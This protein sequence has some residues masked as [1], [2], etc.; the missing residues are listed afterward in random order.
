[1]LR[2]ILLVSLACCMVVGC[3]S[4]LQS[5][6]QKSGFLKDYRFFKPNPNAEDSWIRTT[7]HFDLEAFQNYDRI[8]I[9]PIE[10]WIDENQEY[11]IKD[12]SKQEALTRYL[13][14]VIIEKLDGSKQVVRPGT[15]GSLLIKMAI[16][17]YGEKAPGFEALD[18][19]PFRIVKNVG[20]E[21]YLLASGQKNVIG[22]AGLEA[23]FVDTD[24]GEGLA[25]IILNSV[26]D[27]MNVK[28]SDTNLDAIKA[29]I[30]DWAN[31]LVGAFD[32]TSTVK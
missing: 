14:Q 26:T 12:P 22:S 19:L 7:R 17:H 9:A 15:K 31:R 25:A 4:R 24:S 27:E 5:P 2:K 18:V 1:M 32:K 10:L 29:V 28:D 11:E 21:A 6:E 30:D 16:T 8:A 23:E 20:V 3:S 13:E